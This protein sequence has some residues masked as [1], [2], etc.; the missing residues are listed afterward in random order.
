M[1]MTAMRETACG[2]VER[3]PVRHAAAAVMTHDGKPVEA[4]ML[5]QIDLVLRHGALGIVDVVL[6]VLG[7]AAVAV[8]AQVRRDDGVFLRQFR[9]HAKPRQVGQRGAVDQ[10]QGRAAATDHRVQR[11]AA[12][13]DL[14]HPEAGQQARIQRVALPPPADADAGPEHGRRGQ[15][16]PGTRVH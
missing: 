11:R 4:E 14:L 16:R 8:A 5:H 12:G 3:Q 6:A 2:M 7:L 1:S 13:P 15:G 10:E 9:R